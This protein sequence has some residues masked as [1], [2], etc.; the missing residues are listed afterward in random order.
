MNS[1]RFYLKFLISSLGVLSLP[2]GALSGTIKTST[3]KYQ[4]K[5]SAFDLVEELAIKNHKTCVYFSGTNIDI[6]HLFNAHPNLVSKL[7]YINDDSEIGITEIMSQIDQLIKNN[8]SIDYV[9]I[10]D[11]HLKIKPDQ[12]LKN[13]SYKILFCKELGLNA[14]V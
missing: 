12:Q 9:L 2:M 5:Y 10:Q 13:T 8:I 4:K 1:R 6:C 3:N 11:R 7:I 14:A